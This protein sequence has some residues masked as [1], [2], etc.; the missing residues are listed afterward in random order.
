ML[1][2]D[3]PAILLRGRGVVKAGGRK[4][5]EGRGMCAGEGL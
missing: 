4:G 5:V 3:T 2:Q 1:V